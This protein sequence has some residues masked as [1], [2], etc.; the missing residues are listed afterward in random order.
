MINWCFY[1]VPCVRGLP[2]RRYTEAPWRFYPVPCVRG[3]DVE[4]L[5]VGDA[6]FLSSPLREGTLLQ[7]VLHKG[8]LVS[9][10]S[11]A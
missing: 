10:Q 6:T 2:D 7:G 3:L 11:P 9:I 1:P 5:P 4:G 8:L